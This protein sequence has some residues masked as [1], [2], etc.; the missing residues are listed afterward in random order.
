VVHAK[1]DFTPFETMLLA[2]IRRVYFIYYSDI[3][4]HQVDVRHPTKKQLY[5]IAINKGLQLE[6]FV[7]NEDTQKLV[8]EHVANIKFI[9]HRKSYLSKQ[10]INVVFGYMSY[11]N[12]SFTPSFKITDNSITP[13][14]QKFNRGG[15]CVD[16]NKHEITKFY[17]QT[18][19]PQKLDPHSN[20]TDLCNMYEF[21]LRLYDRTAH[22]GARWFLTTEEYAILNYI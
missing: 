22:N 21:V 1:H 11:E 4:V 19:M 8:R 6:T 2:A 15:K 20:K 12:V 5:G 3:Y 10:K 14:E 17:N 16:K 7:Y 9:E 18:H 13:D